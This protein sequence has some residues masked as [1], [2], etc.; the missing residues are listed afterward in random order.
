M[1]RF[2]YDF[3]DSVMRAVRGRGLDG[4][5]CGHIHSAAVRDIDGLT[6]INCGDC[7]DSCT[8]IVKHHDGRM[9]LIQWRAEPQQAA[10]SHAERPLEAVNAE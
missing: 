5:I 2:C 10:D 9:E 3:E 4:V 8:A 6:Y 7:V 1:T